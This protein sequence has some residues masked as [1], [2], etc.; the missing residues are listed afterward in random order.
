MDLLFTPTLC[1]PENLMLDLST[2]TPRVKLVDFGDAR[3]ISNDFY[4]H[5]L[6]GNPEFAAPE[7]VNGLPVGTSADI[8]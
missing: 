7:M 5:T 1:Q 6:L 3:L 4:I 2:A 8:W